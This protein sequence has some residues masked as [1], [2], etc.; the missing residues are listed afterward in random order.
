VK[1]NFLNP[2]VGGSENCYDVTAASFHAI[3]EILYTNTS[4]IAE[5]ESAFNTCYPFANPMDNEMFAM[6]TFTQIY[7]I[8][9]MT[10]YYNPN[11]NFLGE[12]CKVM[13]SS[14]NYLSNL[15]A[16]VRYTSQGQCMENNYTNY[17]EAIKFSGIPP[18]GQWSRQYAFLQCY[19]V[20]FYQVCEDED[21]MFL[22]MTTDFFHQFCYD[23]F[24]IT[25]SQTFESLEAV[26]KKYGDNINPKGTNIVFLNGSYDPYH[27]LGV[28][29]STAQNQAI[30][31]E[32]GP[33]CSDC[34]APTQYD[35]PELINARE[36]VKQTIKSWIA[37]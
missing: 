12:F 11:R 29:N 2:V 22:K 18:P 4:L 34:N 10:A 35:P 16:F 9:Q 36:A 14:D 6:V 5:I 15:I 7:N 32:N 31:I 33:H 8:F 19:Q 21:C 25:I 1:S 24:G 37:N 13:L 20:G 3:D 28:L 17:I 23:I 26:I 30:L 27:L